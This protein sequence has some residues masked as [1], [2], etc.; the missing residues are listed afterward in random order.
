V[1]FLTKQHAYKYAQLATMTD[2]QFEEML[3]DQRVLRGIVTSGT[4]KKASPHPVEK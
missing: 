1:G 4:S 3:H 2:K